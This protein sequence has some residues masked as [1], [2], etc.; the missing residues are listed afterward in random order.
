MTTETPVKKIVMWARAGR[1]GQTALVCGAIA[2]LGGCAERKAHAIPWA[3]AVLVRPNPPVA[4]ETNNAELASLAPD[5]RVEPP[6]NPVRLLGTRSVPPRPRGANGSAP[7][8]SNGTNAPELVP[9]LSA[10]ETAVAKVQF[11]ES[12]AMV[13]RNLAA[14]RGK[15]LTASQT[16]IVSKITG[17]VAEAREAGGEGDWVRARNLAKKA[18]ILSEDL[19]KSL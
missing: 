10:Q 4:Q 16:D 18:Q 5:F 11:A 14:T 1:L 12:M 7:E 8:S 13:E 19:A 15:N 3:T 6:S 2:A 17:F 9:Q